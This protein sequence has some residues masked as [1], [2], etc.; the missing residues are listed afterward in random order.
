MGIRCAVIFVFLCND[1]C[2]VGY[3]LCVQG[4][5]I[6]CRIFF[7]VV[8]QDDSLS[9]RLQCPQDDSRLNFEVELKCSLSGG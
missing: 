7:G 9:L 4:D 1:Y 3:V 2:F 8:H 5:V 6:E